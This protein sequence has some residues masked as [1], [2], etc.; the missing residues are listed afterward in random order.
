VCV[1]KKMGLISACKLRFGMEYCLI[2]V[3]K[4]QVC[5]WV[6]LFRYISKLILKFKIILRICI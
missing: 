1:M 2:Y 5:I 6:S 3:Y 4:L